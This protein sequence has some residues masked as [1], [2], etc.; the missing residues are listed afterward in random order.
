MLRLIFRRRTN[1]TPDSL[2]TL[3][4]SS[5]PNEDPGAIKS[6]AVDKLCRQLMP[7]LPSS[8]PLVEIHN[9]WKTLYLKRMHETAY[10]EVAN[11]G[12][13]CDGELPSWRDARLRVEQDPTAQI[14][15]V[16]AHEAATKLKKK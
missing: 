8:L 4:D 16:S 11:P 15:S 3:L 13:L 9:T 2:A 12:E 10:E 6:P 7:A 1:W 14:A 5:L